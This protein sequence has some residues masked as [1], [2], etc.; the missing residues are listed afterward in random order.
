[1]AFHPYILLSLFSFFKPDDSEAFVKHYLGLN[2]TDAFYILIILR[3]HVNH[4]TLTMTTN[5]VYYS[6]LLSITNQ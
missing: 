4:F 6:I 3:S 2:L 5:N 1:M